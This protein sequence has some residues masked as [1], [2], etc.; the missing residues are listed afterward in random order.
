MI[1]EGHH[2]AL[3]YDVIVLNYALPCEQERVS[4]V[5]EGRHNYTP[6]KISLH[7]WRKAQNRE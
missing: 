3:H 6:V 2:D 7:G 4:M 1:L 5:E